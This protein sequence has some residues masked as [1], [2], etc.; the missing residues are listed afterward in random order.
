MGMFPTLSF[1]QEAG[2][3]SPDAVP[4]QLSQDEKSWGEFKADNLNLSLLG[5]YNSEAVM[6][7]DRVGWK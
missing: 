2:F 7:M 6:L 3:G 4:N 1:A 5:K